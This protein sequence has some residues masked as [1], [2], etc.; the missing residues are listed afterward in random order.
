M[1]NHPA[2]K[3]LTEAGGGKER[4]GGEMGRGSRGSVEIIFERLV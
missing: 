4:G 2:W 1:G 3:A